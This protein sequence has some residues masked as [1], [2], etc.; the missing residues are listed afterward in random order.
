MGSVFPN[1]ITER[2]TKGQTGDVIRPVLTYL[3][4]AGTYSHQA[5]FDRFAETVHYCA[6]NSIS[7]VFHRISPTVQ[8]A[9]LPQEN[10]IFGIV[11]ETYDL[12]RSPD[13]GESRW[14][15][16]AVTLPIQ[17]CLMVRRGK[18]LR[19]IKK[20]LSHEQALGQCQRFL[21][22]HLPEAQLVS[23]ASTAAAAEAVSKQVDTTTDCAAICSKICLQL[24][25]G[26]ELLYEGIQNEHQNFTRFYVLANH[27]SSP[28][29]N[30]PINGRGELNAL[31]RMELQQKGELNITS[32][33][34]PHPTITDL[35]AALRLPA[36]RIDR[37]PSVQR[38][39]FGSVY[40]VEVID[41][42]ASNDSQLSQG[43]GE[44]G[45]VAVLLSPWKDRVLDAIARV[46]AQGGDADLLGTW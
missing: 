28:L 41:D 11:T 30:T 1:S 2:I 36:V 46:V 4:P 39:L 22:A 14:V 20:V 5:A 15:R 43:V 6:L 35:L 8:L 40:L 3:G 37:R 24:F 25:A 31:I 9:L 23:V 45:V 26:L 16:G 27:P 34:S 32:Q 21:A 33:G 29:P 18:T 10:S 19:N 17:H 7:D 42:K 44:E 12:L 38:E 13:V